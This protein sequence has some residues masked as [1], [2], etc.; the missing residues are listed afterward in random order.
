MTVYSDLLQS[1][2][3]ISVFMFVALSVYR[4]ICEQAISVKSYVLFNS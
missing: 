1:R 4:Q 3:I 2:L